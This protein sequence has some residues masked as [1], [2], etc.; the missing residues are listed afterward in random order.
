MRNESYF[1]PEPVAPTTKGVIEICAKYLGQEAVKE[2]QDRDFGDALKR[3]FQMLSAKGFNSDA[4]F[5]DSGI[6]LGP[7]QKISGISEPEE[8][9]WESARKGQRLP[10]SA[11]QRLRLQINNLPVEDIDKVD[12]S[13]N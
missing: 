5:V 12:F 4:I 11:L 2:L 3:G 9:G 1:S 13:K 7:P 10:S 6:I 8:E